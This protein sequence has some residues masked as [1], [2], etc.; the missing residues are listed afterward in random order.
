MNFK[1]IT[2]TR[3][4]GNYIMTKGSIQKEAMTIVNTYI[5]TIGAPKYIKQILKEIKGELDSNRKTV[6]FNTHLHQ[7]MTDYPDRKSI[8]KQSP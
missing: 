7:W 8:S 6:D 4:K 5:P 2:I 1:T 3:D